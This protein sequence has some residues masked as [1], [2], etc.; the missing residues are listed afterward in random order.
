MT[1]GLRGPAFAVASACASATHAIGLAFQMVRSGRVPARSPA[2][3][4]PASRFGTLKG[5]EA[6]RVLAPD[7]CRPFSRDRKGLV[8]GEGAAVLVLESL[9]DAQKR[10]AEI[11]GEIVG[12]GMSADAGDLLRP[13]AGGMPRAIEAALADA[14]FA[15]DDIH[16]VNAHGTGTAANDE[17]ETAAL[18]RAFGDARPPA[19]DLLDQVDDRPRAGRGRRA[20]VRRDASCDARRHR[21]ADHQL[22]RPGPGLRSRLRAERARQVP[23]TSPC[24]TPSRSVG[25]TPCWR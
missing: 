8:I 14:G 17:T 19:R 24:R 7:T 20:R 25:S 22:S 4:R 9:E 5:W 18:K 2:A 3:P 13:D 21:A 10:A 6:L 1:C 15:R 23:S 16:Y 11:L 12:F